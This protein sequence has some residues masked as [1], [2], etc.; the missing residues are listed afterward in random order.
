MTAETTEV[1]GEDRL[2]SLPQ[3][4]FVLETCEQP[5][6]WVTLLWSVGST[7]DHKVHMRAVGWRVTENLNYWKEKQQMFSLSWNRDMFLH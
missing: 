2:W 7:L 4:F 5:R 6:W 1:T 3:T